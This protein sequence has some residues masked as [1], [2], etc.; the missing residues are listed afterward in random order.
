MKGQPRCPA[1]K[2][3]FALG[4]RTVLVEPA[5]SAA[6]AWGH[7]I[8]IATLRVGRDSVVRLGRMG[9]QWEPAMARFA[10]LVN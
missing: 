2:C 5:T 1:L 9:T 8:W 7:V 4:A 3:A 10:M 6:S